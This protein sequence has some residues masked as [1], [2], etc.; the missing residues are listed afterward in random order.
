MKSVK[1]LTILLTAL[2]LSGCSVFDYLFNEKPATDE[3]RLNNIIAAYRDSSST[4]INY[5]EMRQ[6][7]DNY[8][9]NYYELRGYVVDANQTE[10]LF[11][12][13]P[14]FDQNYGFYFVAIDNPLPKQSGSGQPLRHIAVGDKI[15]LL[16]QMKGSGNYPLSKPVNVPINNYMLSLHGS[17]FFG[18]P[19]FKGIAIFKL[20]DNFL[21]IPQWV[22]ADILEQFGSRR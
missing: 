4:S 3:D 21:S 13:D 11:Y 5:E 7:P 14:F 16:A 2:L 8:Y 22:S 1:H 10:F 12:A 17:D 9:D 20:E 6:A 19:L 18:I 15:T